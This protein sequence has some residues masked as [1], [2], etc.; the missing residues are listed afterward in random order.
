MCH[1]NI[2]YTAALFGNE[3]CY[4]FHMKLGSTLCSV[5]VGRGVMTRCHETFL[6]LSQQIARKHILQNFH[7]PYVLLESL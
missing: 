6:D 5:A 7:T 2:I 1:Q 4:S 3:Y